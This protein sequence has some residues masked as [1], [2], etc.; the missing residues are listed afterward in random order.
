MAYED[1]KDL[2][3]RTASDKVLRGKAFN[4]A[5]NP[6]YDGSSMVFN[7]FDKKSKVSGVSNNEIKQNLQLAGELHKPI[8]RNF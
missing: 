1:L 4:F 7:F 3:R 6:R 8:I 5:K 2:E